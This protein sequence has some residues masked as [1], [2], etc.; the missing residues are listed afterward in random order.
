MEMIK[1][2]IMYLLIAAGMKEPYGRVQVESDFIGK[3]FFNGK[4]AQARDVISFVN[5]LGFKTIRPD[6][7]L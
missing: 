2:I 7:C 3:Y 4:F 6:D 1:Y 5:S